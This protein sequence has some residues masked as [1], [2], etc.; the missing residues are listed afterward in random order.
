ME[1]R[2]GY[3]QTE[4]G[5][6]PQDWILTT[7]DK[8]LEGFSSGMTP[9]RGTP[10]YYTGNIRWITS[11]ELN[12]NIIYDTEEK[13]TKE[14]VIKT[15]LKLLPVGTFLMAIT[16]LEAAGTRGSCGIVGAEA[17][18][19][20]SCMAI[21]PTA[22]MSTE[23]L[24]QFYV[25]YGNYLAFNYCQGTKQQS[26]TAKIVKKLPIIFPPN[27]EEQKAI[28][29]ALSDV[30]ALIASIEQLIEKKRL[31]KQGAMQE[32]LTGKRRLPG[33]EVKKGYKQTELGAIPED[34]EIVNAGDIGVFKGGS[35]FPIVYQGNSS[36]QYPFFKVSDMNNK[37][38]GI[39]MSNVN[40]SISEVVRKKIGAVIFPKNTIVFAKI[41]AAVFLERKKL[42]IKNSCI[43]NNM[44]GYTPNK[45]VAYKFVYY[46]LHSIKLSDLVSTTALPS[47]SGEVLK[48][49]KITL[50]LNIGEQQAI[51]TILSDMDSEIEALEAK[52]HKTR[53]IKEG[54]MQELLT[55]NI[56]L[57][58]E[59]GDMHAS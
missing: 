35:G 44:A 29:E 8:V 3:K 58:Q 13:I 37:G 26:Y 33:F 11:G 18:T 43:D 42:L 38:N 10:E 32:L 20:Q 34:W 49:I 56:R 55:G 12:Y 53:E 51:A 59:K 1:V 46:Y 48:K 6:I 40:N 25:K 50:P 45:G 7:F 54:M 57:I 22:K 47:L 19:N 16:G 31:I 21:F 27:I 36:E 24:Y 52:L 14:A 17:T 23:Y 28:A 39:L 15:N 4:L 9:Y 41:G 2:E 5:V 30:D